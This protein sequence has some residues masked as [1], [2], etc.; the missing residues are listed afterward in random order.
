MAL[1]GARPH[2]RTARYQHPRLRRILYL[3]VLSR[4]FPGVEDGRLLGCIGIAEIRQLPKAR[5]ALAQV[6]DV[7]SPASPENTVEVDTDAVRA[8]SIMRRSGN[9]RLMVVENGRLVGLVTLK[10]LLRLIAFKMDL[11]GMD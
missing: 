10:D 9:S 11:E 4:I 1:H 5:W 8:L 6:F 3:S 7:M 2:R